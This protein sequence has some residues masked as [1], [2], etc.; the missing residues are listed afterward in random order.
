MTNVIHVHLVH[1]KEQACLFFF[2]SLVEN[3]N[4]R[5]GESTNKSF[6]ILCVL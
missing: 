2:S 6:A 3:L 1:N 5:A 4:L